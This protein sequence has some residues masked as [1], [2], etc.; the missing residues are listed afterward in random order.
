ME[1]EEGNTIRKEGGKEGSE[2]EKEK[3]KTE[4]F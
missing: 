1:I 4:T 2:E 3:K